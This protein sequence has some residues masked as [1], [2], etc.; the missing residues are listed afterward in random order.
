M[1]SPL[2]HIRAVCRALG[3]LVPGCA[4][5]LGGLLG[6]VLLWAAVVTLT[7]LEGHAAGAYISRHSGAV[8]RRPEAPPPA[9]AFVPRFYQYNV[10]GKLA[11]GDVRKAAL[12]WHRRGGKDIVCFCLACALAQKEVGQYAYVFP[13]FKQGRRALWENITNDGRRLIE[14]VPPQ[15]RADDAK[16]RNEVE[17]VIRFRNGST[18]QIYGADDPD[19]L[20]GPN[21]KGVVGSEIAKQNPAARDVWRPMLALNGGW[22]ILNS[23]PLGRNH[24]KRLYDTAI[25]NPAEWYAETL[26]V[27]D[28]FDERGERLMTDAMLDSERADG[29]DEEMIQQEYF[30]SWSGV[31]VGSY[32]GR[33]LEAAESEGRICDLPIIVNAP[34]WTAWDI[35]IR[36]S[37]AIWFI[38]DVG[39]WYHVIDYVE[40]SNAGLEWYVGV[41][42]EKGYVYRDHCWPHDGASKEWGSG[43]TRLELAQSLGL[44]PI[45]VAGRDF[46]RLGESRDKEVAEG[47]SAVR[48][49][50]SRCKFDRRRTERGRDALVSYHRE[51]D[52]K[53]NV[54]NDRPYHDW[55]S[56]GADAFRTFANAAQPLGGKPHTARGRQMNTLSGPYAF[57]GT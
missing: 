26:T 56:N 33:Y 49:I 29:V 10:L 36:D 19:S 21:F 31:Q 40:A 4:L 47:I 57:M 53:R 32:Y 8:A 30:C 41:L 51:K 12:C 24:W 5:A 28:T 25:G 15:W 45:R 50:L 42:K 38:Q 3:V 27:L 2:R 37:T 52:E 9:P 43:K 7:P 39:D 11:R 22:E 35:G 6:A 13:T 14:L 54:Y 17:M 55:S 34:V 23:T 48:S 46:P 16:W 18:L 1:P 44:G 20:R